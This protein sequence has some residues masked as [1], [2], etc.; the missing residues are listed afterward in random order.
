MLQLQACQGATLSAASRTA[1]AAGAAPVVWQEVQPR[2]NPPVQDEGFVM[3]VEVKSAV[4]ETTLVL[5]ATK[6]MQVRTLVDTVCSV[7]D[8]NPLIMTLIAD[9]C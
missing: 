5:M 6:R 9:G 4:I 7:L 3:H 8:L 2:I 1:A